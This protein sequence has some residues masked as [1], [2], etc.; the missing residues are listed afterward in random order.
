M[1]ELKVPETF[2]HSDN[3]IALHITGH[4]CHNEQRK[5]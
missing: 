4:A 2:F 1:Q 5:Q 3:F